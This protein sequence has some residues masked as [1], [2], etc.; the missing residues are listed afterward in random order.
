MGR[1]S[2]IRLMSPGAPTSRMWWPEV[3][4]TMQGPNEFVITGTLKSWDISD[5]LREIEVPTLVTS[6][7]YDECTPRLAE[8]VH[9]GI[10]GSECVVFEESSHTAFAEEPERYI[11]ILG[12]FLGRVENRH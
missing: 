2:A 4:N 9:E 3:Y 12:V 7:R 10:P 1:A 8:Q 6:G 5:R 11:R